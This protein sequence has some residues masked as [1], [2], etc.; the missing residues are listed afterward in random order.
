MVIP[1][2]PFPSPSPLFA[3]LPPVP[4]PS[5]SV[6]VGHN[7]TL[8]LPSCD[9]ETTAWCNLQ[10]QQHMSKTAVQKD[11]FPSQF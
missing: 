10:L 4:S 1:P 11:Q 3:F 7:I 9:G 2:L 8:M 5:L 6:Y